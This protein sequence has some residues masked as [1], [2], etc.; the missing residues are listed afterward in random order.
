M[1]AAQQLYNQPN[2]LAPAYSLFNVSQRLLLT[3]HSHQ[4]WPDC[5]FE[6]QQKAW[7][8]AAER[9]DDKWESAFAKAEE[10]RQ[11]FARVIGC[12]AGPVYEGTA[13]NPDHHRPLTAIDCRSPYIKK[14]TVLTLRF[15]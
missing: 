4:A 7:R 8:D 6:G 14:K 15:F 9:V 12:G 10:V 13:V 3:G 11:G 1:V 2:A 5:A